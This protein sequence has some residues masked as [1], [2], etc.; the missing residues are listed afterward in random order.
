MNLD[1]QMLEL[2]LK[3]EI[4]MVWTCIRMNGEMTGKN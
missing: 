1:L 2:K 4:E 3:F